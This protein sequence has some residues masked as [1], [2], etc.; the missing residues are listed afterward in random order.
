MAQLWKT[1]FTV[2]ASQVPTTQ[3]DFPVL[4]QPTDNRFK[5][6]GNGGHV[7]SSSG[8][9]IRPYSDSA[10]TTALT[11][12]LVP[13]TYSA[14]TGTFEM[15]VKV[16]SLSNGSIIYL[17]YGDTAL[18]S[19]GSGNP[20]DTNFKR[21]FHFEDGTT[22]SALDSTGTANATFTNTPTAAAGQVDG[23]VSFAQS[24]LQYASLGTTINPTA[25]SVE[26]WIKATTYTTP[27]CTVF[28]RIQGSSYFLVYVKN[29]GK[30]S[31]YA[32]A[33]AGITYDAPGVNTLSTGTWYYL[34]VT[35]DSSGGL[36]VYL[37][38]TSDGTVAANGALNTSASPTAT[39]SRDLGE[40]TRYWNGL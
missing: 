4:L 39:L 27:Y 15:W 12:Q 8:Y 11:Y 16:P 18:T 33:T 29:D 17:G 38:G 40:G 35:Y 5:T 13:G 37:N 22:L 36:K 25:I 7:A 23:C 19:D 24:S 14:S 9:D 10:L 3:T 28:A 21:V 1:A 31:I 26:G 6:T 32:G 20:F 2:A 30:I 34:A